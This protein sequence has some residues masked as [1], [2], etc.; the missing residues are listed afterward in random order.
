MGTHGRFCSIVGNASANPEVTSFNPSR[1][2]KLQE[3]E[4]TS[5]SFFLSTDLRRALASYWQKS[6]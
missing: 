1:S 4:L 6:T 5:R 2:Y 3:K